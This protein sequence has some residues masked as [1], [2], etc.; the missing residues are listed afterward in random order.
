MKAKSNISVWRIKKL[1]NKFLDIDITKN[2]RTREYVY[3]RSIYFKLCREF[4][5]ATLEEIGQSVG[6][7]HASVIHGLSVFDVMAVYKDTVL[8]YYKD[9]KNILL[10]KSKEDLKKYNDETYYKIKYDELLIEY[11]KL[12]SQVSEYETQ[13][14]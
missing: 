4:T 6:R 2:T 3:G 5:H 1:V 13:D 10:D 14:T 8:S 11:R 12:L 9:L 7:N